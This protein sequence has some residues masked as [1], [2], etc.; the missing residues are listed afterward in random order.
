[1]GVGSVDWTGEWENRREVDE[2]AWQVAEQMMQG[3][4]S[5]QK[6]REPEEPAL[7]RSLRTGKLYRDYN[8]IHLSSVAQERGYRDVR[9]GTREQIEALGGRIRDGEQGLPLGGVVET[10]PRGLRIDLADDSLTVRH[11]RDFART[12]LV[13]ARSRPVDPTTVYSVGFVSKNGTMAWSSAGWNKDEADGIAEDYLKSGRI[14]SDALPGPSYSAVT[15]V[16]NAEQADGLPAPQQSRAEPAWKAHQRAEDI[17][18]ASGVRVRHV[19][20]RRA[21][22]SLDGDTI[23]IPEKVRFTSPAEYYRTVVKQLAHAAAHPSRLGREVSDYLGDPSIPNSAGPREDLRA[24]MAASITCERI[25]LGYSPQATHGPTVKASVLSREPGELIQLAHESQKISDHLVAAGR[26]RAA[27]REQN[28]PSPGAIRATQ[29]PQMRPS[30]HQARVANPER[31]L[32]RS[33]GPAR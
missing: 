18:Q 29:P 5:W 24:E 2:V 25:G 7:P 30:L 27:A 11:S 9:W 14:P 23:A 32:Q 15:N 8:S 22:Y 6:T 26:E 16:Y 3:R 1:M 33:G 17:L 20:G 13:E 19:V 28:S 31:L 12:V 21:S 4:A 10:K